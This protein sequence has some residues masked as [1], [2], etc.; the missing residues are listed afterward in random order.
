[1]AAIDTN[2]TNTPVASPVVQ[3]SP[4]WR[5][6][7]LQC[8]PCS[9]PPS[10]ENTLIIY[11]AFFPHLEHE[12]EFEGVDLASTLDGLVAGV[13]A[14]VVELVL[15][16]EVGGAGAVAL[17]KQVL[18]SHNEGGGLEGRPHHLVGVPRYRINLRSR[19]FDKSPAFLFS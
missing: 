10:P 8:L 7:C 3:D 14:D 2:I 18:V 11:F 9:P 1:M 5:K 6:H 19:N 15:L 17:V 4:S 13:K 12:P 16:E